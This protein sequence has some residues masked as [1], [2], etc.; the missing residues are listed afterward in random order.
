MK[1]VLAV[2]ALL[3]LA[4]AAQA[5]VTIYGLF[6]LSVGQNEYLGEKNAQFHS[7]GDDFS[8]QGNSTSRIGF[9]G[10]TVVSPGIK[11]NFQLE[12]AGITSNGDVGGAGQAFFNRQA[13]AGFSGSFGEVRFGK[14]DSVAFQTMIGFDFNG[15]ANAA[16]AQAISG[17][18]TFNPGR[19]ARSLQYISNDLGGLKVQA[20]VQ[21]K[22]DVANAEDTFALG[23]TYTAGP[24][25][26][27][28]TGESKRVKGGND[29]NSVAG[30][31][32]FGVAKIMLGYADGGKF[33]KGTTFGITAPVA[34][35]N[36]GA[37][38]TKND[39]ANALA[40]E[41]FVNKE[42]FKG[43]YAYFDY[44][45]VDKFPV[46]NTTASKNAYALG[47]IYTF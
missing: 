37:I 12:T 6:D 10:T 24:L 45:N 25:A 36:V 19:V 2:A 9:K 23:L 46:G 4:G 33:A 39:D 16:S 32:D 41:L 31:Y 27:A 38:F 7:G 20:G 15:A 30:S 40:S 14:Q 42:I 11:A 22:G 26:V 29:F 13:W 34:G 43:T 8:S 1:K 44:G 47:V 17:A 5:Q 21:L 3:G 28:Y 35:F 18:A